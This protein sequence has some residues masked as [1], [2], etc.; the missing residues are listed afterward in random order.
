[1]DELPAIVDVDGTPLHS[2]AATHEFACWA[3]EVADGGTVSIL[4]EPAGPP[5]REA[6]ATAAGVIEDFAALAEVASDYVVSAL[7]GPEWALDAAD[8]ARLAA[9]AFDMPEAVVWED[10]TWMLRFAEC[11]LA[12]GAEYGI[13]VNFVG[14]Q[15][16]GVEDL[17]VADEI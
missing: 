12:I 2:T 11:T 7:A 16:V 15:P 8:R 13:G 5:T 10:G 17:S 4:I 1:M 9:D 14:A 3:A 6:I